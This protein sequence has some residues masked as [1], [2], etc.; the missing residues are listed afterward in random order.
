MLKG[1]ARVYAAARVAT[2]DIRDDGKERGG[3]TEPTTTL[4]NPG[5]KLAKFLPELRAIALRGTG[6][7]FDRGRKIV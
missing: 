6:K 5:T 1:N 3:G 2:R 7:A 4:R